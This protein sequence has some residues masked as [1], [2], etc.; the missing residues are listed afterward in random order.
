MTW[1]EKF[2]AL[3]ALAGGWDCALHM[4]HPGNWYVHLRSVDIG[5]HGLLGAV[6]GNGDSPATAVEDCWTTATTLPQDQYIVI[7][8]M[9]DRRRAVRWNGF[10]WE[11]VNE[12]EQVT[13]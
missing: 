4:R 2:A 6:V 5:G 9:R 11:T 13:A 1:E 10:M 12:K 8:A 7:H 3:G